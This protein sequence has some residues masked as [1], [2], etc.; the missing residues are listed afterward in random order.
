MEWG[1]LTHRSREL[2]APRIGPVGRPPESNLA[3]RDGLAPWDG[4]G[5]GPP[6]GLAPRDRDRD[7]DGASR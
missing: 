3:P 4:T 7:R 1:H 2:G 5:A 6:G